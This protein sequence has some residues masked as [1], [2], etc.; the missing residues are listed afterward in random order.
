MMNWFDNLF[1]NFRKEEHRDMV[2]VLRFFGL[3]FLKSFKYLRPRDWI[4]VK[5]EQGMSRLYSL[6]LAAHLST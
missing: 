2:G 4:V 5:T 1:K 6:Y 3:K